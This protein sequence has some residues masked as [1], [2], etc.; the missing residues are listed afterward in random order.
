MD[1]PKK[2]FDDYFS[3]AFRIKGDDLDPSAITASLG[4]EPDIM[5]KKGD[6][7]TVTAKSGK[8]IYCAPHDFGYWCIE[9]KLD[10]HC[11]IQE[12]IESILGRIAPKEDMFSKLQT[13]GFRMDFF[14]GYF[15]SCINTPIL[16]INGDVLKRMGNLGI[17]L[18]IDLYSVYSD[19]FLE[20]EEN[21]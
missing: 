14:C 3:V 1:N 17:E 7:R 6:F 19:R 11:R 18:R 8:I 9:S 15:F 10:K 21:P 13:D 4:I 2:N 5:W 12:H 16:F 20:S